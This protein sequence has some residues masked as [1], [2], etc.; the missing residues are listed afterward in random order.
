MPPEICYEGSP[1]DAVTGSPIPQ[2]H[3]TCIIDGHMH[4]NSGACAPLPLLYKKGVIFENTLS[5]IVS[6]DALEAL[7]ALMYRK[8]VGLQK[9]T[10]QGLGKVAAGVNE[11]SYK[12]YSQSTD[13]FLNWLKKKKNEGPEAQ[14]FTPM[15]VAMMDMEY[16]HIAGYAGEKIYRGNEK[17]LRIR[18]MPIGTPI[19]NEEEKALY[20]FWRGCAKKIEQSEENG[21]FPVN[22]IH[23][24]DKSEGMKL[25]KWKKQVKQ[26]K[27]SAV[28]FPFRELPLYFYEPRR[29]R[30]PSGTIMPKTMDYGAWDEPFKEVATRTNPGIF[31]GF[32]MYPPLGCKPFDELCEYLPEFYERCEREKI[33]ILTHCSPGGMCTHDWNFYQEFDKCHAGMRQEAN[34]KREKK[35]AGILGGKRRDVVTE[36]YEEESTAFELSYF[37][38]NY[39]HP[40]QWRKVLKYFPDLHLCL[41]HFGGDEWKRGGV[42]YWDEEIQ[43]EWVKSIIDLTREYKNVYTDIS[44]FGLDAD[45]AN[46]D[47]TVRDTF[48]NFLRKLHFE[49][50]SHLRKKIIFGTDWYL[51][52]FTRKR[53]AGYRAFCEEIKEFLDKIDKTLWVRFTLLNPW[54]LYRFGDEV[55][56]NNMADELENNKADKNLVN[57]RLKRFLSTGKQVEELNQYLDNWENR[58]GENKKV[59]S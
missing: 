55:K 21:D 9:R 50:Y 33:P 54:E 24:Y 30:C 15:V 25:V 4:I 2:L 7:T 35:L 6:R 57:L 14:L 37:Y 48:G 51:T 44:C 56:M 8:G 45:V 34:L 11:N 31:A 12:G 17:K 10:T 42:N 38:Y 41:A 49:K 43:S 32:K 59:V 5:E 16:A 23:E 29:W 39:V 1:N 20:F 19:N 3:A 52:F 36:H 18:I 28:A 13:L 47:G 40:D 27:D 53:G 46:G 22:I 26:T 58:Y